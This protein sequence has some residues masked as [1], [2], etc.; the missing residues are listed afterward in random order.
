VGPGVIIS[1]TQAT[2][3]DNGWLIAGGAGII[4]LG[5]VHLVSA[6]TGFDRTAYCHQLIHAVAEPPHP[7]PR[8]LLDVGALAHAGGSR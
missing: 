8:C 6:A 4:A 1:G 2:K 5:G 7:G 3:T